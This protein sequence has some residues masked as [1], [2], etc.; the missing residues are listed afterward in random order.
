MSAQQAVPATAPVR[1]PAR[2]GRPARPGAPAERPAPRLR[3]VRPPAQ[4]RTHVPFVVICMAILVGALLSAL[5]LNTQMA[6]GSYAKHDM[7]V[8]LAELAQQ[9]QELASSIEAHRS[10]AQLAAQAAALGM[11]PASGT[12][13]LRLSDGTVQGGPEQ[14]G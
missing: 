7:G 11:Q 8:E 10:P 13:W 12:A 9:Q 2:P 3:V 14:A 5:V 1:G 6:R 4:A